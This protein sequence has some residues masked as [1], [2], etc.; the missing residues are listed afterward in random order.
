MFFVLRVLEQYMIVFLIYDNSK[1]EELSRDN[2]IKNL[3]LIDWSEFLTSDFWL[4]LRVP[5]PETVC[6]SNWKN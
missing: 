1:M 5:K 4:S 3:E 2:R 6:D